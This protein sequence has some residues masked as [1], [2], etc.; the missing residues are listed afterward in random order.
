LSYGNGDTEGRFWA[1]DPLDGTEGYLRG[2]QYA[3]ALALIED[4][5]VVLGALACP[6]LGKDLEPDHDAEGML[7]VAVKGQGSWMA[8]MKGAGF[9]R[10]AVSEC[11]DRSEAR[12]LR[13]VAPGHIDEVSFQAFIRQFEIKMPP[14]EMESQVKYAILKAGFGDIYLRISSWVKPGYHEKIW[15]H[16]AGSILVE[17]AGGRVMNLKGG[18]LK[19]GKKRV[20]DES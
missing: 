8:E 19:F 15:D 13:S 18:S 17:E 3:V 16:A 7:F 14:I 1:L 2:D 12:V 10:L 20:L 4:G 5:Q 6:Q 9:E 11:T